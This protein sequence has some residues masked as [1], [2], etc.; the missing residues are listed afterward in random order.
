MII[1]CL[2]IIYTVIRVLSVFYGGRIFLKSKVT[3]N[4]DNIIIELQARS[5]T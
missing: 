3:V 1:H 4:D 2:Y 5:Q